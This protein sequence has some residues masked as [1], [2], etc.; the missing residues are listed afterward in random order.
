ML[1]SQ[2]FV[3]GDVHG[4]FHTFRELVQEHWRPNDEHLVQVGDL[5]DR[6]NF[7]PD[8]VALAR[9]LHERY[10]GKVHFVKGNHEFEACLYVET[11]SNANWL[12]QGGRVTIEQYKNSGR[13][14][15]YDA[16]WMKSLPLWYENSK[17]LI[18]HAGVTETPD[19]WRETNPRGVLWNRTALK[20]IVKMQII[21]HTPC[22]SPEF[23]EAENVWNIDTGVYKGNSLSAIRIGSAGN[24]MDIISIPTRP[25]DYIA[26]R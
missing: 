15:S 25:I 10:M 5:I 20:N 9:T 6:G 2:L 24:V 16:Q 7:S 17:V 14:L 22:K 1:D 4:C 19:P 18:T 12:E 21:G 26:T 8:C 13:N 23:R 3:I 11:H